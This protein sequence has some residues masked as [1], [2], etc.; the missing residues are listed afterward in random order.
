[1]VKNH[2]QF[3]WGGVSATNHIFAWDEANSVELSSTRFPIALFNFSSYNFCRDPTSHP[4]SPATI[5]CNKKKRTWLRVV[6]S[7]ICIGVKKKWQYLK[8]STFKNE[9]FNFVTHLQNTAVSSG[10]VRVVVTRP[11]WFT[12]RV[13][14]VATLCLHPKTTWATGA[15]D[16]VCPVPKLHFL[17]VVNCRHL[18]LKKKMINKETWSSIMYY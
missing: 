16:T 18:K 2:D 1:M 10:G 14:F 6:N 7:P 11:T 13:C 5:L 17:A 9:L 3:A 8:L 15:L 4:P 12:F